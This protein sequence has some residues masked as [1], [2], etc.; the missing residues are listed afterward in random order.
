ML[1]RDVWADSQDRVVRYNLAYV[2]PVIFSG[3]NGRVLGYDSDHGAHHRHYKGRTTEV[4]F[5]G[6]DKI[7]SRFEKEWTALVREIKL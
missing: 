1:R 3:D 6:F 7:E 5:H 2:N 4:R